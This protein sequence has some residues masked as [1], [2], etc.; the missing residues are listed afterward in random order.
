MVEWWK[1]RK[2]KLPHHLVVAKELV[3]TLS[4]AIA[5]TS[6]GWLKLDGRNRV[7]KIMKKQ[8]LNVC[9]PLG[10]L[11]LRCLKVWEKGRRRRR[12]VCGI[13]VVTVAWT[14]RGW[15]WLGWFGRI[16]GRLNYG[17]FEDTSMETRPT[18]LTV[19]PPCHVGGVGRV[20]SRRFLHLF[21]ICLLSSDFQKCVWP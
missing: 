11:Q 19:R 9:E 18:L 12:K 4:S 2:Q 15:R 8:I 7:E 13:P 21:H 10:G 6:E 14:W 20:W 5:K 17:S 16:M 3:R 1:K